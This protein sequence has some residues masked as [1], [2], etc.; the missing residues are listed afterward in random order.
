MGWLGG[1]E[2]IVEDTLVQP[3]NCHIERAVASKHDD[4]KVGLALA[5][6]CH[7]LHPSIPGIF[8]STRRRSKPCRPSSA[9]A[10]SPLSTDATS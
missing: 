10:S 1:L 2:H 5:R 6:G 3:L 8:R 4:R 9:T 7:H